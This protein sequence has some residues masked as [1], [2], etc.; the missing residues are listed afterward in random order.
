MST[1]TDVAHP[2]AGFRFPPPALSVAYHSSPA[3]DASAYLRAALALPSGAGFFNA[4]ADM[5]ARDVI[6]V[7]W[8]KSNAEHV[9][10]DAV[11][12]ALGLYCLVCGEA[13]HDGWTV[14]GEECGSTTPEQKW[15]NAAA[16]LP[17]Q[18]RGLRYTVPEL[19]KVGT[20]CACVFVL[21]SEST[22][23]S[24]GKNALSQAFPLR[25]LPRGGGRDYGSAA[26]FVYNA[27]YPDGTV[28]N[29]EEWA[30]GWDSRFIAVDVTERS[31]KRRREQLFGSEGTLE[32]MEREKRR[33]RASIGIITGAV[34][35]AFLFAFILWKRCPSCRQGSDTPSRPGDPEQGP[36]GNDA[37]ED[38]EQDGEKPPPAY[39]EVVTRQE[40]MAMRYEMQRMNAPL[41]DYTPAVPTTASNPTR[42]SEV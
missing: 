13:G 40:R 5:R 15:S 17:T 14:G 35:A 33:R 31:P 39:H 16:L 19:G 9:D 30:G 3:E 20:A 6:D 34:L 26:R 41:P 8:S 27:T 4:E 28:L 38:G 23:G 12:S 7:H 11:V 29:R 22:S 37:H 18:G 21:E 32:E 25:N 42:S 2:L 36:R 10:T 24:R 1:T